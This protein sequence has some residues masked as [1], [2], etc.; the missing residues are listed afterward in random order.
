MC[1]EIGYT[2]AAGKLS[3]VERGRVNPDVLVGDSKQALRP[4]VRHVRHGL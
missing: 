2:R 4:G 3:S 1:Q